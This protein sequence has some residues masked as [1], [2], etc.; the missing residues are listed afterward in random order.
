MLRSVGMSDRDFDKMMRF[1]CAFY[2]MRALLIG[3]PL[4]V[5]SS[6]LIH[7]G[8]VTEEIDFALPWASIGISVV[9]VLFV[10]FDYSL[11]PPYG[12]CCPAFGRRQSVLHFVR[13]ILPRAS[14]REIST[15]AK[16]NLSPPSIPT[17]SFCVEAWVMTNPSERSKSERFFAISLSSSTKNIRFIYLYHPCLIR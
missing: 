3:L 17:A 1:E 15:S 9:S 7:K 10:I 11:A 5:I 12:C 14:G 8:V 13:Y 6:W 4:A 2:G 16:S